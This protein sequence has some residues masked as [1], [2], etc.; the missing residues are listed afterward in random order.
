MVVVGL[1]RVVLARP[2]SSTP[3]TLDSLAP[4]AAAATLCDVTNRGPAT[5]L[6]M[7]YNNNNNSS[8]T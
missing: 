1:Q 6:S 2:S 5:Q 4:A 8:N 3:L 7:Q